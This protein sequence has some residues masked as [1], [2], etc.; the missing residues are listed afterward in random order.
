M[1]V[2]KTDVSSAL[3]LRVVLEELIHALEAMKKDG[4][5]QRQCIRRDSPQ[6]PTF[7]HRLEGRLEG[8]NA[9]ANILLDR[10]NI[11]LL[12]FT[13]IESELYPVNISRLKGGKKPK[14][15]AIA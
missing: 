1:R 9:V 8:A 11:D 4:A 7:Q 5:H 12:D 13:K 3:P 10:L 2:K 14:N 15:Q 6:Y